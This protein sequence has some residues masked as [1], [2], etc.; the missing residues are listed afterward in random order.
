MKVF[1]FEILSTV[2]QAVSDLPLRS[3]LFRSPQRFVIML[4]LGLWSLLPLSSL[5]Q[6]SEK[7]EIL[8]GQGL[9]WK[10]EREGRSPSYLF[11]TMHVSDP[12]ILKQKD[13]VKP[14]L[15]KADV[16]Y[17]EIDP[18]LREAR[19]AYNVRIRDDG[20]TLDEVLP[21]EVYSKIRDIALK[22]EIPEEDL[23]QLELWAVY[24]MIQSLLGEESQKVEE[25]GLAL[26]FQLGQMAEENDV[27][28]KSLETARE[29]LGVFHERDDNIFYDAIIRAL[30]SPLAV[31][32]SLELMEQYKQ[33]YL[34]ENTSAFYRSM[35]EELKTEPPEIYD[36]M[37]TR[38]I[39]KRN[40]NMANRM[41]R[42]LVRGNSFTAV[43]ALH[44]PGEKGILNIL[45]ERGY[46]VSP[47]D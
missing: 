47:M 5:T 42:G 26:D 32:N 21:E 9:F 18:T 15:N 8:Y 1:G 13:R 45:V 40:L 7:E 28:V 38:L 46:Q 41:A 22:Q 20:K 27:P 36:I 31:Q 19:E 4:M 39:D 44:L 37:K 30:E 24:S 2:V 14:Y 17:L 3:L 12:R 11:G 25:E 23:K 43:G 6:A 10:I 34:A 29:Q 35:L 33:W 16:L